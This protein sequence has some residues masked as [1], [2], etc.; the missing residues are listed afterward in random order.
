[1]PMDK[2][3]TTFMT[4]SNLVDIDKKDHKLKDIA[5]LLLNAM[6]DWPAYNQTDIQDFVKDLKVYF[7]S[8]LTIEKINKK[9]NDY[10]AWQIEAGSS[11]AALIETSTRFFN[12]PDFDT[13]LDNV[14]NFYNDDF[15][16]VDFIA[17][18]HYLTTHQGGRNTPVFSG[19]RPQVKF[20]FSEMQTSG[21]QTFIDKET[22]F[23]GDKVEAKIKILSPENFAYCLTEGMNF[24]FVEGSTVIGTGQIKHIINDKLEQAANR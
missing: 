8:P 17:E 1:M 9:F 16:K 4:L 15:S 5:T 20:D 19:Y 3:I 10:N 2:K 18:L 14:L 7:G 22:V 13:I 6:N 11:I 12:Q 24:L 23:P 21:Q